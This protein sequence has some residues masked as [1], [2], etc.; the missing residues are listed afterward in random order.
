M[1]IEEDPKN[2]EE[3]ISTG[4]IQEVILEI[5]KVIEDTADLE[6]IHLKKT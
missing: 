3:I 4:T 2:V 6:P 1:N 5:G